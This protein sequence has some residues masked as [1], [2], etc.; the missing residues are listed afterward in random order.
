MYGKQVR[1][2]GYTVWINCV[3]STSEKEL[4]KM[5]KIKVEKYLKG[6]INSLR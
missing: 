5:A 4:R 3:P 1:Y 2:N 6:E